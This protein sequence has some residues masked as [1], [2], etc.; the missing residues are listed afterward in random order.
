MF[1]TFEKIFNFAGKKKS[2]L[3]KSII[4]SFIN[5][6]FDMLQIIELAAVMNALI[7]GMNRRASGCH[8]A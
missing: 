1:Q 8:F 2:T 7:S 6:V 4:F 5:S 3:K